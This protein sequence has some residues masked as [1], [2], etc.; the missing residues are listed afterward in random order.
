MVL[1]GGEGQGAAGAR[2]CELFW[3]RNGLCQFGVGAL[4]INGRFSVLGVGYD[5]F[6]TTWWA[7]GSR[8]RIGEIGHGRLSVVMQVVRSIYILVKMFCSSEW[9]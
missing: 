1:D 6:M 9:K 5:H 8:S 4:G 2:L 7:S 3:A